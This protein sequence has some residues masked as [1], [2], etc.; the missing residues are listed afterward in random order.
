MNIS[1][2]GFDEEFMS[3]ILM[4]SQ[5]LRDPKMIKIIDF[6]LKK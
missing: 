6:L 1:R 4:G 5:V 2:I 3:Y